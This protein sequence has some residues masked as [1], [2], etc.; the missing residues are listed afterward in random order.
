M[1]NVTINQTKIRSTI[2]FVLAF[3]VAYGPEVVTWIGGME[4]SPKWLRD[5][6]K[7]LGVFIGVLTSKNGV[8]IL[9]WFTKSPDVIPLLDGSQVIQVKPPTV[10]APPSLFSVAADVRDVPK[11]PSGAVPSRT[12][13]V[14][15]APVAQASEA[16]TKDITPPRA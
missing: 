9:N 11:Q 8:P 4:T 5:V 3:L 12:T 15:A 6:A 1:T 16:D 7:G 2:G 14:V 13:T 10:G